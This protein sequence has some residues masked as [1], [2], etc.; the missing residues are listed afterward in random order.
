MHR[1]LTP[2]R[3]AGEVGLTAALLVAVTVPAAFAAQGEEAKPGKPTYTL[4]AKM[5][6]YDVDLEYTAGTKT[7]QSQEA[8]A[9][10]IGH[11]KFLTR[12]W[13]LDGELDDNM[14]GPTLELRPGE[15]FEI[16]VKNEL[17]EEGPYAN[18][19]PPEPTAADW[20]PVIDSK[21]GPYAYLHGLDPLGLSFFNDC[22]PQTP[23]SEFAVD[24]V[25]VPKNFNWTN[26]HVHGLEVIP[27]LFDPQGTSNPKADYITIK[28]GEQYLYKF[29][30]PEDHPTG[31]FW[32]HPHRHNS[33][34]IQAWGAMAGLIY[35]RGITDDEVQKKYGITRELPFVVHDPHYRIEKLPTATEPGIAKPA[36]FLANQNELSNYSYL[37]TGKLR[38]TI[39]MKRNEIARWRMLIATAENLVS[40]RIVPKDPATKTKGCNLGAEQENCPFWVMASDGI[41]Y[42]RPI[43]KSNLVGGGGERHDLLVTFPVAGDYEVWSDHLGHLQFFG[44]GPKD[45]LLATIH[46]TEEDAGAPKT[47][48]ADMTFTPGIPDAD[49]IRP[50]EIVRK[51]HV[52]FDLD[53]DTCQ[54][55]FPQFRINDER[56]AP[57]RVSFTSHQGDVEEWVL[58]NPNWASHPFHIHVNS[59]Q[60]KEL[61]SALRPDPKLTP[62][63]EVP[64]FEE[65]LADITTVDRPNEWRDT[66]VIPP[67]GY[68]RIWTRLYSH[69]IG[70]TVFHCHFLAHEETSMIQNFLI[71]PKE[72]ERPK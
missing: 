44:S 53:G 29:D 52:V 32:Y 20:L 40:F 31:T 27:H 46:V 9:S 3:R 48:I 47:K 57:D 21:N 11:F 1:T 51:R 60:V 61:R 28:P 65:R 7:N 55:P 72:K 4:V 13:T 64:I 38:P 16:L 43:E 67:Q 70:K 41:T 10:T 54:I 15:H 8:E 62:P 6:T 50:E 36:A 39:T 14:L 33:V 24:T 30:L 12:S 63:E 45:Q 56:Y 42:D 5:G 68:M 49:D 35:I 58:V 25:N 69:Y 59:F 18:L 34:A 26:L 19:G 66:I 71:E 37:V 17:A 22:T 2:L 23:L